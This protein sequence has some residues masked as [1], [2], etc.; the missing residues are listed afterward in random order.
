MLDATIEFF[1]CSNMD[2]HPA[3]TTA[4]PT[5]H[6]AR[7]TRWEVVHTLQGSLPPPFPDTPEATARRDAA[8]I[9]HVASL[10]PADVEEANLAAQ[11]VA[12]CAQALDSLRLAR[13]SAAS[14]AH[15]LRCTAQSASMMRQARAWRSLL[16]RVQAARQASEA[17][18][19]ARAPA[20]CPGPTQAASPAVTA[21]APPAEEPEP[22]AQ[23]RRDP[24]AEAEQYARQ[25][26][27]RAALIRSLGHLPDRLAVGRLPADVVHAIVT[28]VTP[29]LR[30]LSQKPATPAFAV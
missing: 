24:I 19:V 22:S 17:D 27:K 4:E 14:L 12:A 8:A 25:H 9:E 3:A 10:H 11:Y 5:Y 23:P 18:P 21:L 30:A 26:R 20:A 29:L 15:I 13:Q 2:P 7:E 6:L 16:M 28:G 1:I